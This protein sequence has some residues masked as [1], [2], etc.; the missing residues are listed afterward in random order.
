MRD[1]VIQAELQR[2]WMGIRSVA[3]GFKVSVISQ[4]VRDQA[5][6]NLLIAKGLITREELEAEVKKEA[7][8]LVE[9]SKKLQE[10]PTIVTP[11]QPESRIILPTAADVPPDIIKPS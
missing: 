2:V 4:S 6:E 11:P 9:E 5:L 8:K 3:E 10:Q 7:T 1:G